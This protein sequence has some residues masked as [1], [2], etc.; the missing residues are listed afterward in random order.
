MDQGVVSIV[1]TLSIVKCSDQNGGIITQFDSITV[2]TIDESSLTCT[3]SSIAT[4]TSSSTHAV[5]LVHTMDV[6]QCK[7]GAAIL[8]CMH[9]VLN[10]RPP[11]RSAA[12]GAMVRVCACAA[13]S[14]LAGRCPGRGSVLTPAGTA[15]RDKQTASA[16]PQ[17][18]RRQQLTACRQRLAVRGEPGMLQGMLAA[19]EASAA[20]GHIGPASAQLPCAS[21]APASAAQGAQRTSN[22]PHSWHNMTRLTSQPTL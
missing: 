3:T 18:P 13:A 5:A 22:L 21:R 4:R 12:K 7:A 14:G 19:L 8:A 2:I 20:R 16:H 17:M 11:V 1:N 10:S 9:E 15:W 6:M